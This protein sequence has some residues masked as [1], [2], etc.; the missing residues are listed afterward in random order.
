MTAVKVGVDPAKRAFS[1]RRNTY[2]SPLDPAA[3]PAASSV[4]S[5]STTMVPNSGAMGMG[6]GASNDRPPSTE[7][8]KHPS[9]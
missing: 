2:S 8:M 1:E 7:R 9:S 6:T 3:L 5:S 4:P